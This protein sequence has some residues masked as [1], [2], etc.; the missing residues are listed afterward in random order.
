[1]SFDCTGYFNGKLPHESLLFVDGQAP[2]WE[3]PCRFLAGLFQDPG[4]YGI[5]EQYHNDLKRIQANF[6]PSMTMRTVDML[7]DGWVASKN[8]QERRAISEF[9][10]FQ[11]L[12]HF[13]KIKMGA[14]S[15]EITA[16]YYLEVQ[17]HNTDTKLFTAMDAI[18]YIFSIADPPE[19]VALTPELFFLPLLGKFAQFLYFLHPNQNACPKVMCI[20][21]L[22]SGDK[23][24]WLLGASL[25]R[26]KPDDRYWDPG[27]K[28]KLAGARWI[29]MSK[30]LG[31]DTKM[32]APLTKSL[33]GQNW[34]NCAESLP[35]ASL[36]RELD[37]KSE[38]VW[39]TA[40]KWEGNRPVQWKRS[41]TL[42]KVEEVM[43]PPCR[44]CQKLLKLMNV[45]DYEKVV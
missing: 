18:A 31:L 29:E 33:G 27:L 4:G 38:T 41:I 10:P 19:G 12:P 24:Q 44:N 40:V 37:S 43:V 11:A 15:G 3:M 14:G 45:E 26:F 1:M 36:L 35:F 34:G 28:S 23:I 21:T 17:F 25:G 42:E 2:S 39:G 16:I 13:K 20:V 6:F 22:K 8:R 30:L 7:V 9:V 32:V 5:P